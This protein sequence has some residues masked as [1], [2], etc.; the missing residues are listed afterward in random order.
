MA[1]KD[2]TLLNADE[3][4]MEVE[5]E[6]GQQLELEDDQK[7]NLVG[8][9]NSRFDSAEDARN[10]DEK[11]W[12]TAFENYRGLYKKN[13]KFRESEKSRV[14]VKITKTK[15]LAA[16]G[17]LVDVI[18]G[19]G[20]FPIG[21]A[22]TKIPEGELAQAHLDIN[23]PNPG[24]ETSEPELP[25]DIGNREG[26]NVNPFDVGYEGDGRTLGPGSTFMKG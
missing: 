5:G 10:S 14:F 18:F 23:N 9:I 4:Y 7:L 11:R 3:I 12:I 25:D 6:S 17:Q 22:E 13:Q 19:T 16:F 15:V 2:N 26:A 1:D 24:I 21:I 8:I 20:K